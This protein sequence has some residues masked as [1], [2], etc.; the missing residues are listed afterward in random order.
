[1][2]SQFIGNSLKQLGLFALL[3]AALLTSCKRPEDGTGFGLIP[4]EDLLYANQTDDFI[5]ALQNQKNDSV[6]MDERSRVM[7]GS[8]SDP[9]RPP[10]L[11][12][13]TT[14]PSTR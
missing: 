6:F 7:L 5:I 12:F 1:M 8:I 9:F 13:R 3:G 11:I 10:A 2:T 14:T 4:G